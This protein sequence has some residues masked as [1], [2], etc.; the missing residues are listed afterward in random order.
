MAFGTKWGEGE[1]FNW[2]RKNLTSRIIHRLEI[3]MT[4]RGGVPHRFVVAYMQDGSICR[5][6]RR[7]QTPQSVFIPNI[8]PQDPNEEPSCRAADEACLVTKADLIEIELST[9]W[10]IRLDLP[11]EADIL[12]IISACFAIAQDK[13]ARNYTLRMY[14]CYFFSWT[15]VMLITRHL[16]P[17]TVPS[18]TA[19]KSRINPRLAPSSAIIADRI[20]QTLLQ[21]AFNLVAALDTIT[22]KRLNQ[23]LSKQELAVWGLPLPMFR[24][25]MS[26]CFKIELRLGLKKKLCDQVH[27]QLETRVVPIFR[28]ILESSEKAEAQNQ[29][30]SREAVYNRVAQVVENRLWLNQLVQD[31]QEPIHEEMVQVLWDNILDAI[32]E[33]YGQTK[34]DVVHQGFRRLSLLQRLKYRLLGKNVVQFTQ[35]LSEALSAALPAAR[36]AAYGQYGPGKTHGDMFDLLFRAGAA[37]ALR[38]AKDVVQRTGPELNNPKRDEMWEYV[39]TVWDDVWERA[40]AASRTM[41]VDVVETTLA[42]MVGWVAEDVVKELGDNERQKMQA[43]IR[44]KVRNF[45]I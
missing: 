16:L 17:F 39:W 23:G 6:D 20:A 40:L 30:D 35:I 9:R 3:R 18:P 8:E 12:L 36:A 31:L 22:G 26:Q 27:S 21:V 24:G 38:A 32:A 1:I 33:G 2:Y 28:N 19:L 5:F 11:P 41:V 25:L 29:D 13:K 10:E 42:D 43:I 14:N 34:P 4:Q 44:F 7:P 45:T 37:E 15:I